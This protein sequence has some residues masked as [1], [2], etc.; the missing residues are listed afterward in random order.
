MLDAVLNFITSVVGTIIV[1]WTICNVIKG[2]DEEVKEKSATKGTENY[3]YEK[4][5]FYI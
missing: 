4:H 5:D 1:I 2:Y 3:E